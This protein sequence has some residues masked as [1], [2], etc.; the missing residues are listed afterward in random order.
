MITMVLMDGLVYASYLFLVAAGLTLIFG[1]MRV[2]NMAHGGIYGLG[3]YA[4]TSV[5]L[6]YSTT[7]WSPYL[8][9]AVMFLAAVIVGCI[10]GPVLER[11]VLQR[12]YGRDNVIQLLV[13]Y[14]LFL[15]IEDVMPLIWGASPQYAYEPY[16]ILPS[17]SVGGIPYPGYYFLLIG[18]SVVTGV[19]VWLFINRTK[20]GKL[21]LAVIEDREMSAAMGLNISRIYVTV[22]TLGSILAALG[23]V[24]SA[25]LISVQPGLSI[26]VIVLAFAIVVSGGLGSLNGAALG[27]LIV[28]ITR[29]AAI[30]LAP[31]YE[32]FVIYAIMSL[33]L[34]FRPWGLLG[35]PE[36]KRI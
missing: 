16:S 2:I 26:N 33:I 18:V 15:I 35:H 6:W 34:L 11:G 30:H 25:P 22:F 5:I 28:G 20:F 13:T 12:T 29:A 3:A 1:V 7:G 23:G 8:T 4:A 17:V 32:I 21:T 31:E 10:V 9:Y 19:F 36:V 24:F 27:A 14:A